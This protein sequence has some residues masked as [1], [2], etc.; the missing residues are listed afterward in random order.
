MSENPI[1]TY[2]KLGETPLEC[3]ERARI[4]QNIDLSIPMTYAGRLDPMAEGLM[5]L[6]AGE[7]CKNKDKY[8]G[9]D[10][11]YEFEV[12]VGF[13]TDTYDLLGLVK[14]PDTVFRTVWPRSFKESSARRSEDLRNTVSGGETLLKNLSSDFVSILKSFTGTFI[15]KYPPFSSKTVGGKQLFQL[16]KDDELPDK[17]PEHEVTITKLSCTST[18]ILNKKELQTEILR[19]ISLINGDFRQEEI[20]ERWND[21]FELSNQKEFMILSCTAECSSGTYIRQLVHDIS[22]KLGISLVTYSIKRKKIGDYTI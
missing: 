2:K 18:V 4:E 15:Q 7:E 12:L 9:F 14:P 13:E 19:R 5:I 16:S 3:L 10:K 17:L 20:I 22:E 11:T 21:A 1:I 6:L 8:L